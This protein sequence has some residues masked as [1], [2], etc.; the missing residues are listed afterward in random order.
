MS[1]SKLLVGVCLAG[2]WL[3]VRAA[4]QDLD[5]M[6]RGRSL[7][8]A[9]CAVCHQATGRGT[10][11]VY[12]PLAG[13]DYLTQPA[14]RVNAILA[15][16]QGL[17]GKLTVN[18]L[19]YDNQ[20]PAVVLD[21]AQ[22]ADV[23]TFV[24]GSWGNP[25]GEFK[26]NEIV[27]VRA[28]SR[29]PTFKALAAASAYPPLPQAPS[30]WEL[31]EHV[32]LNDFAVRMAPT[33]DG[34]GYYLLGQAG[35][36]WRVDAGA[37]KV[38]PVFVAADYADPSL[39]SPGTLG[40]HCDSKG[41]IWITCNQRQDSRPLVTNHISIF[42]TPLPANARSLPGKPVLW[43]RTAYP[44]GIGPYNHGVSH[45]AVGPDGKLYVSSGSRTDGG[46]SGNEP[47]LGRMGETD[48]T[49][50]LWRMDPESE[51]PSIEVVAKGIR[52]A[53]SFAWDPSGRL[54]TVSNGPDAH[55]GE[56]M[57]VID[58][59]HPRH[60]GFPYQFADW[61]V[62][63]KAYPHTPPAPPGASFVLPVL[64]DGPDGWAA[65]APGATF[66]PHSSPAGMI[67][68]G[69]R[70]PQPWQRTFLVGRFGNL[71]KLEGDRDV[72]FDVLAVE[73][74][75]VGSTWRAK[76]RT[77]VH[78]LGRPIDLLRLG[79]R[80]YILEYT[81]PTDF[82]SGRGWLPGRVLELIPKAA[83]R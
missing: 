80:V 69:D 10:P 71:L 49:A 2:L 51:S 3:P 77:F 82:R 37:R 58:V 54:F 4:A 7:Y 78:G 27:K 76:V 41:R 9:H 19:T 47:N 57:D 59:N 11:G 68:L 67:W 73:P 48:L 15:V 1:L 66:D 40:M 61:P 79:D 13:S 17:S 23:L 53:W 8:V 56:E 21:D 74:M 30:G 26:A 18:G 38:Q 46:E 65:G 39:G 36:V 43:F 33:P 81:R 31:K 20:M 42:R 45:L 24:F 14:G 52:N 5:A 50:C 72:G 25:G 32:R 34:K 64:N 35:T 22:V 83:G 55:S 60:H 29:F 28:T 75:P 6:R 70:A 12:P 44:H 16:V 62:E 63:R